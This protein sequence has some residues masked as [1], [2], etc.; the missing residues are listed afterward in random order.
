[1]SNPVNLA[2]QD[3]VKKLKELATDIDMCLFCTNLKT[4]DGST[5][6]PMSTAGVDDNGDI[7]FMSPKDSDKNREIA[8]DNTVQLFYSHPGKSSYMVVN[9][10][11]SISFDKKKI[12][13]LWSPL[14]K[15]WLKQ[16]KEDPNI[17]LIRVTNI[18]AHYWDTTGNRMINFFKMVASVATGKTLVEAEEGSLDTK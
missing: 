2:Q 6:R 13:E 16:G 5:C 15:T 17:S 3:A 1:M 4:G 9:G 14:S 18:S 8:A 11:A 10:T 12:E 7:W